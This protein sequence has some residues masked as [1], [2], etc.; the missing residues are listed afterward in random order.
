MTN[1]KL[2]TSNDPNCKVATR[3][4]KQAATHETAIDN[5]FGIS[6]D[7]A[8]PAPGCSTSNLVTSGSVQSRLNNYFSK[9]CFTTPPVMGADGI[10][11]AFGDSESGI[12]DGL[13]S[14]HRSLH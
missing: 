8:Q 10:G 3:G 7:R 4:R 12:V 14:A 9:T 5:I 13:R 6:D 2:L 11:T 1:V